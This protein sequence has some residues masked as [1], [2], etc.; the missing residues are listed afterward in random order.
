[1]SAL[2]RDNKK[3]TS[4]LVSTKYETLLEIDVVAP[5]ADWLDVQLEQ[6]E[7]KYR[8][9]WTTQSVKKALISNR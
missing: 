1:M 3:S 4:T 2:T 6:L 7:E 8:A 5:F 9:D